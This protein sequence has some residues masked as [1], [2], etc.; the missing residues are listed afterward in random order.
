MEAA[1]ETKQTIKSPSFSPEL[2]SNLFFMTNLRPKRTG[3]QFVV[4]V[5]PKVHA[6]YGPRILA[7]NKYG[8]K[9]S[10]GDWFTIT[11]EDQPRVTGDFAALKSCDVQMAKEWVQVNKDK[12]LNIWEDEVDVFDADL[13]HVY[14]T[15]HSGCTRHCR[16]AQGVKR[17]K[18]S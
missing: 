16:H 10:E 14:A 3:L 9:V 11:I 17:R 6:A 4:Y 7:S 18:S 1:E 12:L 5:S 15:C 8:E 2:D 13:Q